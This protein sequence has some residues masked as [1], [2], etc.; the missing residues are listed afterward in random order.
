MRVLYVA[1][2]LYPFVKTGGLGDV[3]AAL[4]P[5]LYEQGVDV[6]L[7]LP[8]LPALRDG[9][10]DQSLVGSLGSAFGA[11]DVRVFRGRLPGSP[12][13]VYLLDAPEYFD[14]P[15]NPYVDADGHD[16]YDNPRRF[17]LFGWAA[18]RFIDIDWRPDIVHAHDWHAGLAPAWLAAI[19]GQR[20]ASVFTI[21]NLAYQGLTPAERFHEL[22][23]PAQ[24]FAINGMEFHGQASFMK[25]GLF[26]ADRLTTVSPTYAR[27]IQ[28]PE[29]GCG[30]DG[31]LA[32]RAGDLVGILN[33]V[34]YTVWDPQL[35]AHLPASYGPHQL[36]PKAQNKAALQ[37]ELGLET[38]PDAPLFC[39]V[40]R[41]SQQK[42]IDIAVAGIPHIVARGGQLA[43]LGSGDRDLEEALRQ[44]AQE[45]PGAVSA[46]IGYD[47]ALS[48]RLI[49]ASDI[50][51]VPS[52]FEPCGLTQLYGMRYGTLPLVAGVGGLA[53]TVTD[54]SPAAIREGEA[55]G[56]VFDHG[57]PGAFLDAVDR[58]LTQ[59][60]KPRNWG[61]IRRCGMTRDFSWTR[62][63]GEY[64][65]L[66]RALRPS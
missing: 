11:S 29:Q 16:W 42:G 12:V 22:G 32:S 10:A 18:A 54:A 55:T 30:L 7:F 60:G 45:Y 34:D 25:G 26:Y 65:Q 21:H 24:F 27:E 48:H 6:R 58:A 62:S 53:D 44:A 46:T 17:A 38:R 36:A 8:R 13:P 63:A 19:G 9:I 40:T 35:D 50:I 47:E 41:L 28:R 31:L 52:R 51:L 64:V 23:L 49:G 61:R 57:E 3:T 56:F 1:A 14:R 5:A 66:Y 15:G 59:Y 39:A 2:E 20:P 43:L 37:H 33:G 4:P